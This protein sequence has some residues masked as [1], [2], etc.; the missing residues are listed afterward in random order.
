MKSNI[1]EHIAIIMDG[2][3]RWATQRGMQRSEGHKAGGESVKRAVECCIKAGVKYLTLFSFSSENWKRDKVEISTLMEFFQK[4]LDS[5]FEN[6]IKNGI[7]LEAIG[8]LEKLP[9]PVR[10]GLQKNI[11]GTAGNDKLVV[12]LAVSYGSRGEIVTAAKKLAEQVAAKKL[13]VDKIDEALFSKTLWTANTPDPDLLIRTSGEMR[14]SN[15]LLWQIA[16]SE[17]IVCPEYWPDFD[18]N[19]FNRC[20]EEYAR[21]DR[22][23]GAA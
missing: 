23:F 12:T 1:P 17:I 21:R 10:V 6:L 11:S 15:F 16:Y 9:M 22:R 3:G 13:N 20:L 18:E 8:D 2:N 5:E 19:I 4:A 14:V 7:R